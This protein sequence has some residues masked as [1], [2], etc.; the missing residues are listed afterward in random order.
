VA[1]L[2]LARDLFDRTVAIDDMVVDGRVSPGVSGEPADP[3]R[4]GLVGR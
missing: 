2:D 3:G 1:D 4:I